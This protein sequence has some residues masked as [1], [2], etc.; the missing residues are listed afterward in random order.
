MAK[1][2]AAT[3]RQEH[4]QT[5]LA[6]N[7][8][9]RWPPC[10]T[11]ELFRL[12]LQRKRVSTSGEGAADTE[13][14]DQEREFLPYSHVFSRIRIGEKP[15]RIL[16]EGGAGIGKTA[17]CMLLFKGWENG[18][19]FKKFELLL[20]L[21]LHQVKI[22]KAR[23]LPELICVLFPSHSHEITSYIIQTR[24]KKV[25]IIADGLNKLTE[26]FQK[27]SFLHN[28][29]LGGLLS[30]AS[31]LITSRPSTSAPLHKLSCVDDFLEVYGFDCSTIHQYIRAKFDSDQ[32]KAISLLEQLESNPIIEQICRIPLNCAVVCFLWQN[33]TDVFSTTTGLFTEV[34][35][36]FVYCNMLNTDEYSSHPRLLNIHGLPE[37]LR[38]PWSS[39][40]EIAFQTIRFNLGTNPQVNLEAIRLSQSGFEIL[41]M[42]E[43]VELDKISFLFVH[44]TFKEYFAALY[45]IMQPLDR[46]MVIFKLHSKSKHPTLFF[47]FYFGLCFQISGSVHVDMAGIAQ[48]MRLLSESYTASND[49][50]LLCHYAY[51]AK[52]SFVTEGIISALSD[53]TKSFVS[54]SFGHP[55]TAQD[56]V[57]VMYI[58]ANI[59]ERTFV[60]IDFHDCHLGDK[61]I[62]ELATVLSNK[63]KIVQVKIL[64]L[65]NNNLTDVSVVNLFTQASAAFQYL[66]KLSLR[67]NRIGEASICAIKA[68]LSKSSRSMNLLDLSN[69]RLLTDGIKELQIAIECY[70]LKNLEVLFLRGTLPANNT[71]NNIACLYAFA[72][73][74]SSHCPR[75]RRL[76]LSAID[77]GEPGDPAICNLVSHFTGTKTNLDLRLNREYMPE[78]EK[79]FIAVM[80][81]SIRNKGTIDHTVVHGIIV[82]PGRSG[83]DS[84]MNRLLGK[85]PHDKSYL[86]A[87]TGVLESVVK[88]EVKK[89][90]CTTVAAAANSLIWRRLDYNEE[91]LELMMTTAR[92]CSV[93][94]NKRSRKLSQS[95]MV[96][97]N[98]ISAH[99]EITE[100]D[101]PDRS[102]SS[103]SLRV[104]PKTHYYDDYLCDDDF[105]RNIVR[106]QANQVLIVP[107]QEKWP[108]VKDI[109]KSAVESQR[110]DE[111][112]EHLESSWS[113]YLTNTGGQ[114]E[115]QELL[116]LLVC[117]PSVFF[118][119]FPLNKEL[120]EHYTVQYHHSDAD[121]TEETYTSPSTLMDEILQTLATIDALDLSGH[122]QDFQLKPKVFLIGTHKDKLPNHLIDKKI[123]EI[124]KQ[125]QE[126]IRQTSLFDQGSIIFAEGAK[127][128]IF[129]V[130]NLSK[131]DTDFQKIRCA[132]QQTVEKADQFT[133]AC[134]STWLIF[135][136]VLRAKHK[137]SQV[138]TLD[139][140]FTIAQGCGISDRTE[141]SGALHFIHT[142]LGLVRY[143][144]VKEL[145]K[146]VVVDPQ[147]LFDK[148][149]DLIVKTFIS[150]NAEVNEIEDFQGRGIF[151]IK[152]MERICKK[153]PHSDSQLPF[154]WLLKLLRY[155]RIAAVFKDKKDNLKCFFPAV[156]CHAPAWRP[157]SLKNP[158]LAQHPALLVAFESGFCPRGVPGALVTY[159]MTDEMQSV[160]P[161][162]LIPDKVFKNQVS[163][164]IEGCGDIILRIYPTH[165]QLNLDPEAEISDEDDIQMTCRVVYKC[166]EQGMNAITKGYKRCD[167]FF[168][169]YCTLCK[170][171]KR[172]HPAKI[173]WRDDRPIK[174]KC[175]TMNR[176]YS[177]PSDY[178]VWNLQKLTDQQGI[179][180]FQRF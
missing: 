170:C 99:D 174:L 78:V 66:V 127:Q 73:A 25:L 89:L 115:F 90:Y 175:K 118:I 13:D 113:L 116:P 22:A 7:E 153:R 41:G 79:K 34:I 102:I 151:S 86:S 69:N 24:G 159:L 9:P 156:L 103:D 147:I 130:N 61:R 45:L 119:T 120:M 48:I 98:T 50:Y 3:I 57:T 32:Q 179:F 145:S 54:M 97:S 5:F 141:L 121:H 136:L 85:E 139:E 107:V 108:D 112:R 35:L 104:K 80:E 39:V 43:F 155:L 105:E 96:D 177:L 134:P 160:F 37:S 152:T 26:T 59:Q 146:C 74:I 31:V 76:D 8:I 149:T 163:F 125:I 27:G 51:E 94:H 49:E 110:M 173:I 124:D 111:L 168:A 15:V 106:D 164:S 178:N 19:F 29:L 93:I 36:N 72:T 169:Y 129:T 154:K 126:M 12:D 166:I 46:Q 162:E 77:L 114:M 137:S 140:C 158:D 60:E 58:I 100:H 171:K 144:N 123:Q 64:N 55:S 23:S 83:K 68:T 131:E 71:S 42:L 2:F 165:L 172:L 56:C 70:S 21:P 52:H 88:V 28:L 180:A 148:I 38:N 20:L 122:Q 62:C 109:L 81:D 128:L 87:S 132:L 161:W 30:Q 33:N 167:Y 14:S 101:K 1:R 95:K 67:D 138:L 133:I 16:V 150:D 135:S 65:N 143:F 10:P 6:Y 142:R 84:L 17:L 40:C 63:A 75:L 18:D 4:Q 176:Q 53:R 117:G 44:P 91:A 92:C 47:R 157:T 82:G 11:H